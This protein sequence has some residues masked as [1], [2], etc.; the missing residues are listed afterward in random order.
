MRHVDARVD[1]GD[2]RALTLLGDLVGAHH[3]LGAEVGG[4]LRGSLRRLDATLGIGGGHVTHVTFTL[5][6]RSSHAR[7][8]TDRVEGAGGRAQREALQRL[9]V[10]AL[11]VGALARER[12]GH[13]LVDL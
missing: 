10:L 5:E 9:V 13:G 12:R 6:E 3:E 4:I 1:D 11:H 8:V 2:D 7:E